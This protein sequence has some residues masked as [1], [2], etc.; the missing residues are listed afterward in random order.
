M[1]VIRFLILTLVVGIL[2]LLSVSCFGG[3]GAT[4]VGWFNDDNTQDTITFRFNAQSTGNPLTIDN[5]GSLRQDVRG[6]FELVDI[7]THTKIN[8]TF[9]TTYVTQPNNNNNLFTGTCTINDFGIHAFFLGFV[10]NGE[11]GLNPGDKISV[12]IDPNSSNSLPTY[13]GSIAGGRIEMRK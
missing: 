5:F 11:I 4:G 9:D 13:T 8:G 2:A 3:E 1:K 10:D 12:W 7:N 6:Q